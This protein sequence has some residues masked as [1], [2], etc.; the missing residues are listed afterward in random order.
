MPL[1][2]LDDGFGV[3]A[4]GRDIVEEFVEAGAGEVANMRREV[5]LVQLRGALERRNAR[6]PRLVGKSEH[7][8]DQRKV[9]EGRDLRIVY[10]VHRLQIDAGCASYRRRIASNSDRASENDPKCMAVIPAMR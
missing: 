4:H 7:P 6:S 10:V 2:Q 8:E 1:G 5:R 3:C 9:S